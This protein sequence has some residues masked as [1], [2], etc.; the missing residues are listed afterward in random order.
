M[1]FKILVSKEMHVIIYKNE[2][3][4]DNRELNWIF[5]E[6]KMKFWSQFY[7]LLE[8]Y[9][10][11]PNIKQNLN[12]THNIEQA[13]EWLNKIESSPTF[14]A[15]IC[16]IKQ[17]LLSGLKQLDE[18]QVKVELIEAVEA[19]FL[20]LPEDNV[21]QLN[22]ELKVEEIDLDMNLLL[23]EEEK[24]PTVIPSTKTS[25]LSRDFK[26]EHCDKVFD[27]RLRRRFH[28]YRAHV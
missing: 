6:T 14:E 15:F 19:E 22:S 4:A 2:I 26:C 25:T 13:L 7:R 12:A 21:D 16:P 17:Q 28:C 8:Y 9:Q 1:S 24:R 18:I 23:A 11:E 3:Q 10:S 5:E 20:N 27:S